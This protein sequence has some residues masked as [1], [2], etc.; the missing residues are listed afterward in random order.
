[1]FFLNLEQINVT[2]CVQAHCFHLHQ[3]WTNLSHR[4]CE[5]HGSF[6]HLYMSP[7][8]FYVWSA[9]RETS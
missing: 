4:N 3:A 6:P 5:P 8:S 7:L 2:Y 9:I 1:M